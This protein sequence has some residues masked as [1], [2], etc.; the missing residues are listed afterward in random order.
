MDIRQATTA[1][2][3]LAVMEV[4]HAA[5]ERDEPLAYHQA[6]RLK[7]L[8]RHLGTWWILEEGGRV[9]S[10]LMC[11]PLRFAVADRALPGYGLGAVASR[12]EARRRG[13][14][15]ALCRRAIEGA[16]EAGRSIGLLFSAISP[17]YY[18]RLGFVAAPAWH[19][20]GTDAADL[21]DSGKQ[22]DLTPV[23]PR[24]E[25][26]ALLACY[27]SEHRGLHV[28][29]D[30]EEWHAALTRNA[31]D[32]F[33]GLGT[34][35]RGYV[36]LNAED[37]EG[38]DVVELM[39]APEDRAS[40]LRSVAALAAGMGRQVV[41]GWFDPVPELASY[42]EDRGRATTLPMVRGVD[43]VDDARFWGSDYF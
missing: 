35:L 12:P 33:L 20:V 22:A 29:R 2:D 5:T 34:P 10:S 19:H 28:I 6:L 8:R 18:G 15:A 4:W 13:H 43:D 7:L 42:F 11:Y 26:E 27:R 40:A 1:A 25:V 16:E 3:R 38:L 36:R 32:I 37:S 21:A 17:A 39:V 23:D 41:E 31:D 14:A 24:Q 30:D 9:L